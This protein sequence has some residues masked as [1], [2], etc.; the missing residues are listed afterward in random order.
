MVQI[1]MAALSKAL[2]LNMG[3]VS[4]RWSRLKQAMDAGKHPGPTAYELLWKAIKYSRVKDKVSST[5]NLASAH[6]GRKNAD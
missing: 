3:A 5:S 1:D 6:Y 4:K 2:N